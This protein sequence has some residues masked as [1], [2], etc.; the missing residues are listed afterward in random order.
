MSMGRGT[1]PSAA[2]GR[3]CSLS[4]P[5]HSVW[6]SRRFAWRP[7]ASTRS[8][9]AA[10]M[11]PWHPSTTRARSVCIL[12]NFTFLFFRNLTSMCLIQPVY[13]VLYTM[14]IAVFLFTMKKHIKA[15]GGHHSNSPSSNNAGSSTGQASSAR[16]NSS[17]APKA[18]N[19]LAQPLQRLM[20]HMTGR[21][22]LAM[23]VYLGT[24][25]AGFA[26]GFAGGAFVGFSL[27]NQ[28]AVLS[29]TMANKRSNKSSTAPASANESR[30]SNATAISSKP[31]QPKSAAAV[32]SSAA[33]SD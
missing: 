30:T 1:C 16:N 22:V 10:C 23:L 7:L 15:L 24:A 17:N 3:P 25:V 28:A 26:N 18:N 31:L 4:L 20:Q 8:P 21:I 11:F 27:Q 19:D 5:L 13:F 33:A 2:F 29:S 6:C 14:I 32:K 9:T 12:V